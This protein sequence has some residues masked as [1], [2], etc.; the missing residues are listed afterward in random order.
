MIKF[1]DL[2]SVIAPIIPVVFVT[3]KDDH[4]DIE[5]MFMFAEK[6]PESFNDYEILSIAAVERDDIPGIPYRT[7]VFELLH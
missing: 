6:V 4:L 3:N 7:V 5:D 1:K 2:R